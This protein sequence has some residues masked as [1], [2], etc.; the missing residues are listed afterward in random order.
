[1]KKLNR[2]LTTSFIM[3]AVWVLAAIPGWEYIE[4][5]IKALEAEVAKIEPLRDQIERL[6]H[7]QLELKKEATTAADALPSFSYRP[8]R[9][10]TITAA[11]KS[12]SFNTTYR[13]N[14][15]VYNHIDGKPNFSD[16]R[17]QTQRFS[18]TTL[19]ELFPR[20]N[21]LYFTYCWANC[22]YEFEYSIDGETSGENGRMASVRDNELWVHF[23][24]WNPYLPY[25]SI[26]LRRGAGR[27]HVSRS[28]D[29]DGKME[30]S[31]ILDGFDW[32]G[33]GSHAGIGLGWEG[34]DVGPGEMD[35]FL[36]L[37]TSRQGTHQEFVNDNRKG[38]MGFFGIRPFAN[39]KN[40]WIRGFE[41]G[42]G[43]QSESQDR[44]EN[45]DPDA[46]FAGN[47]IRV[48][49]AERRGRQDLFRPAALAGT[50]QNVGPGFS[51]VVIPGV[52]WVIG[53][54]FIRAVWVRTQFESKEFG[55]RGI[56]GEGWTIDN[57][58]F[59]WSPKGFLTGSQ[60]TPGSVM[61]SWGFERGDMSCGRGCDAARVGPAATR[62][63]SNTI[64]NRET[65][66]WYWVQPS[67]GVGVW[68]HYWTAKNTPTRSQVAYGC[69]DN[70]TE[71]NSG[72][73]SSKTCH[74]HS[75][76]TGFRFRW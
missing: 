46:P 41:I 61:F 28:S 62:F 18:G 48:R 45:F 7:Q 9:G 32:G 14:A 68:H 56:W 57:Q 21:R 51:W 31:I 70:I 49:P 63:H 52:K 75:V 27:T 20:R 34:V 44:P 71:A 65:A 19:F 66:I 25:F 40:K 11:D 5:Q 55:A 37:A 29:N 76:N 38:F 22:F 13:L 4:A 35:L 60:T 26:G 17:G 3:F 1:M 64:L 30:H 39:I 69:A 23:D 8:G 6:K 59:L 24:Q 16:P 72:K 58:I 2:F 74:W 10:M 12:W 67:F 50:D 42:V 43:Y 53:P 73:G 33:D 36:N 15:Y 54:Y 47:E